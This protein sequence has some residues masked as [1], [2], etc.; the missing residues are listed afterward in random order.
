MVTVGSGIC[1]RGHPAN[2]PAGYR[3]YEKKGCCIFVKGPRLPK[4][5]NYD[6][7]LLLIDLH[8]GCCGEIDDDKAYKSK[9]ISP[10]GIGEHG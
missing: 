6:P 7:L 8:C 2:R 9:R 3:L 10:S 1:K 4:Y 5:Q